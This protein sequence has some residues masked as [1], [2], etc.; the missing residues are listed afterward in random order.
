MLRSDLRDFNDAY[1]VLKGIV[2]VSANERDRDEM[3][4]Q[5]ILKNNAPFCLAFQK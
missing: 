5:V 4:R 1:T 3:T 2:T